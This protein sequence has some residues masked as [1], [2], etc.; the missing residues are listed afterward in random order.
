VYVY[1][2]EPPMLH[3]FSLEVHSFL[4]TEFNYL[5]FAPPMKCPYLHTHTCVCVCERVILL[6]ILK[7]SIVLF[8]FFI[9]EIFTC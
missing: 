1:I 9:V 4:C 3:M 8:C 7:Y 5:N 6:F 2:I